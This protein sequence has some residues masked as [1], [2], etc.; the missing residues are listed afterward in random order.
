MAIPDLV[1]GEN[2]LPL[3]SGERADWRQWVYGELDGE[4]GF[5]EDG[6]HYLTDGEEKLVW[7]PTVGEKWFFDLNEGPNETVNR[8]QGPAYVS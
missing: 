5:C 3:V 8:S 1:G 7:E 6:Y 4:T 2:L